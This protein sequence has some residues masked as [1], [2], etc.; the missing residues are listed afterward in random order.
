MIFTIKRREKRHNNTP[1]RTK[2]TYLRIPIQGEGQHN[3]LSNRRNNRIRKQSGGSRNF[4]EKYMESFPN[5]LKQIFQQNN[6]NTNVYVSNLHRTFQTAVLFLILMRWKPESKSIMSD[7]TF[8][9]LT[10]F[11]E[12]RVS[13]VRWSNYSD[14]ALD[15]SNNPYE[16]RVNL[17]TSNI[18]RTNY[19]NVVDPHIKHVDNVFN[20]LKIKAMDAAVSARAEEKVKATLVADNDN[21]QNILELTTI[22]KSCKGLDDSIKIPMNRIN[23]EQLRT[24]RVDVENAKKKKKR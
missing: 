23:L 20:I 14:R 16:P 24:I 1:Y 8:N 15:T 3:R 5:D 4:F 6:I 21:V 17:N 18:V 7:Y 19:D 11:R 12:K 22:L 2:K 9:I 10:I 13:L